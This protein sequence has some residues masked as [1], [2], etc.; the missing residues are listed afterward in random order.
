MTIIIVKKVYEGNDINRH[1][2]KG[3]V[4]KRKRRGI[5]NFIEL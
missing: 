3:E 2:N 5:E 4:V 1:F